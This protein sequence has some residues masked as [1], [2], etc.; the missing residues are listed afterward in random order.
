LFY[1]VL[2]IGWR[3]FQRVEPFA[4]MLLTIVPGNDAFDSGAEMPVVVE[5]A[6]AGGGVNGDE[7]S[8]Y[9]F[10]AD[11]RRSESLGSSA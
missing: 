10:V 9:L 6:A 7:C 4:D 2:E 11:V 8:V 3:S 1:E 5:I